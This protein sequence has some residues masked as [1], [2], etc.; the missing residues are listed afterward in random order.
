MYYN[1]CIRIISEV[2][3]LTEEK[4]WN[5]LNVIVHCSDKLRVRQGNVISYL[6]L[7][8]KIVQVLKTGQKDY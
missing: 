8:A 5:N 3:F 1:T 2:L 6:K 7:F 4:N